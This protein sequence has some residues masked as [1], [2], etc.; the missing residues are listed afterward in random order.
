ML[1][2]FSRDFSPLVRYVFAIVTVIVFSLLRAALTPVLGEGVPF[3]LYY[4]A[5]VL[6]AWFGGLWPGILSTLL[7]GLIAWYMFMLPAYSV[8]STVGAPA[9][10][11]IFFLAGALTSLLAESLHEA[12]RTAQASELRERQERERVRVTLD[13]I[14][15]AVITTDAE[16]RVNFMNR[17]AESLIGWSNNEASGKPLEQVFTI[18]NEQT[19]QTVANPALRA[20]DH[21]VIVGLANHSVLIAKDGSERP[22]DD[23]AAPIHKPEIGTTGAVLVFRDITQRRAAERELWESRER[24]RITLDSV[25]DALITTDAEAHVTYVNPVAEKLLGYSAEQ[26]NGRPLGDV[27]KIVNEFSRHVVENPV[28]RVLRDGH[29]IGLANHTVLIRPDGAEMPIDDSAAPLHDDTGRILGVVLI[30]RDIT[31]RRHAERTRATLAAIVESSDDAIISKDLEGRIISWNAGAERLFGY[32]EKEVIGQSITLIIPSDHRDEETSILQR[33][34]KGEQVDHYDTVRVRKDGTRVDIS[35]MVSPVK[36]PGGDILGASKIARDITERKK[37]EQELREA[38]RQKDNFLAILA[39][40]LRNPLG[41]I[42]NAVKII[43]MERPDDR[44]LLFFCDIIDRETH[45]ITRLLDDLLD[46][47]RIT[48]G[49]FVLRKQRVDLASI[50]N[51]A[52]ETSRPIIDDE[53]HTLTIDLPSEPPILDADSVR[54]TQVFS[55]LLNNAAKFTESGGNIRVEV[56]RQSSEAVV[57]VRDFGIGISPELLPKIFGMFV[58]GSTAIERTHGGLGLGLTLARDIVEL[59]GGTIEAKSAGP[60]QGSEFIVRLPLSDVPDST[61]AMESHAESISSAVQSRARIVVVDDNKNQAL[62]LTRLLQRWGHDVYVANDG[63]SAIKLMENTTPDFALIDIGLPGMNGYELARWL[64]EQPQF[65]NVTLIAQT[66]WGREEDLRE[67]QAAG[68]DHHLVK[69]ID[70]DRL[71][72]ILTQSQKA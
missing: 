57:S 49:K 43:E 34:R 37:M 70:H 25:G 48:S 8:V 9:Q 46:I 3:I 52:V 54:L 30:F 59:H 72:E 61:D 35:L 16:G 22:I 11:V 67:A 42:R 7:G 71:A 58:Q 27:F 60:G 64:R 1:A 55:N 29:V 65:R 19:R 53:A 17:V 47:S 56:T 33:I 36:G 32:R 20:L 13:S 26:V 23:S 41:P 21:G 68:F 15:D 39:H 2:I 63:P 18:V 5:I 51:N 28:E 50:V 62:S 44:D 69:P 31:E 38:D 24:L 6:V 66:G 4:P 45:Q 10:L 40:E 12:R 14:G